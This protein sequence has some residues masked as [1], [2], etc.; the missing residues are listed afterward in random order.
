MNGLLSLASNLIVLPARFLR[1]GVRPD[2]VKAP[3]PLRGE[4]RVGVSTTLPLPPP[5]KGGRVR[6]RKVCFHAPYLL[7]FIVLVSVGAAPLALLED[8]ILLKRSPEREIKAKVTDLKPDHVT[9]IISKEE[10]ASVNYSMEGKEGYLDRVSFGS[11]EVSCKIMDM[12]ESTMVLEFPREEVASVRVFFQ[13]ERGVGAP[14]TD[15]S[16]SGKS[17]LTKKDTQGGPASL[18]ELKEELKKELK[19]E[20]TTEKKEEEK[21][22]VAQSTGRVEGR[23]TRGGNPLP[24]C[25]V[26]IV[27]MARKGSFLFKSYGS[28]ADAPEFETE[29]DREGRYVFQEVPAGDYKLYW[30]PPWENSWIRR[31]KMEPDVFVQAGK[32]FNPKDVDTGRLT[33]N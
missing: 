9:A 31:M 16:S 27:L 12:G 20:L 30:R 2:A 6:E 1:R 14:E 3:S 21:A 29:T 26:K 5:I 15:V 22:A 19:E 18:Q 7:S 10:V 4:G 23:V 17:E 28:Q 24:G 11:E 33:L 13:R 32:T 8:S 25:K